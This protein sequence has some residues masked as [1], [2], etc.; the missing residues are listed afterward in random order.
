MRT[1]LVLIDPQSDFCKPGSGEGDPQ[2]GALYVDGAEHD[3]TRIATFVDKY[4]DKIDRIHVTLDCHHL[5]DI[6]HPAMWKNS[7]GEHPPFF[8][9]ITADDIRNGVWAPIYPGLRQRFI[10]YCDTLAQ[11][12]RFLL[13]IWP[14]HCLIGSDGN[15]VVPVLYEALLK[16]SAK[17]RMNINWVSKGSNMFTEHYSAVKAEV[18][19]PKDS[20]TQLN[21]KFITTIGE[22]DRIIYAGEAGSH[23]LNYTVTDTADGFGDD[24]TYVTKMVLL[25]DGTSPVIS[26]NID[27]PAVQAQFIKDMVARGMKTALTTDF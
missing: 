7:D 15:K 5:I 26:P 9:L 16:W 25:T 24:G 4:G 22:A 23:C 10:D 13:C 8:T 11:S 19:D 6:A 1:D 14:P 18:P 20:S 17:K 21:T 12:G 27:F 2:R 3:M